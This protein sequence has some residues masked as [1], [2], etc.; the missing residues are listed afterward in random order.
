MNLPEKK[1][2]ALID[3]LTRCEVSFALYRLPW[4]DQCR[5]VLQTNSKAQEL[6][7]LEEL[8][9]KRGFLMTPFS[10]TLE[11]P[12]ILIKPD[13]LA[14]DWSEIGKALTAFQEHIHIVPKESSNEEVNI[15]SEAD[16]KE[17]YLQT[18]RDFMTPLG[19][20]KFQ[21]L[22][23]TRSSEQL[24]SEEFSPLRTFVKAS[25]L[26]PRM[27]VYLCH[28]PIT[29]T[30]IGSTPEILLSGRD[31]SW[32]TVA[33]AG[34]MPFNEEQMV[35]NWSKKNQEEQALVADYVRRTVAR[36]DTKFTEKEPHTARA[37]QL[38]H[39]K[40]DFYF[41]LKN[42]NILGSVLQDLHPTP[43]V[44]GIPKKETFNFIL[45]TELH[46]RSYYS[47]IVGWL[48]PNETT[49]LYVNLRCMQ[50]KEKS[51]V[52]YAGGGILASSDFDAEWEET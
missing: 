17:K 7:T 32:H 11:H 42:K 34:T 51:A 24:L 9:E 36:F 16:E 28:T 47:G 13:V 37:G 27:L 43:A 6:A 46:D 10:T 22:V 49:D 48:D 20:K 14:T 50:I 8:N 5:L 19:N 4:T 1:I 45:N 25:N 3:R 40:S 12:S 31:K 21:K 18:F 44:C 26:Y 52:L 29:G 15:L 2:Q 23:L 38:V 30:W 39:L 35:P 41:T 33:L